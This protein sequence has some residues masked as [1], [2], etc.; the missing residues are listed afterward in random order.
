MHI[1]FFTLYIA[2]FHLNRIAMNAIV[3]LGRYLYA[4]PFAVFSSFHF[5]NAQG[6]AG[7]AFG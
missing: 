2:F 1:N 5:M 6:M 7:V 3:N 4:L